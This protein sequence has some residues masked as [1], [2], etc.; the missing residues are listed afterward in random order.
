MRML[1]FNSTVAYRGTKRYQEYFEK[2]TWVKGYSFR[3]RIRSGGTYWI[4]GGMVS[5]TRL[6]KTHCAIGQCSY[7]AERA[8]ARECRCPQAY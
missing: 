4:T 7:C 8:S 2:V 3:P 6:G 1:N 5:R